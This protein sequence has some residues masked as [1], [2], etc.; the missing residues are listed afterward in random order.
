MFLESS[1]RSR[2]MFSYRRTFKQNFHFRR[3]NQP[4]LNKLCLTA[5]NLYCQTFPPLEKTKVVFWSYA[6]LK[7]PCGFNYL[8]SV[9]TAK[10][11]VLSSPY[12]KQDSCISLNW[13]KLIRK[14]SVTIGIHL[15]NGCKETHLE[16]YWC[17]NR[18]I[19]KYL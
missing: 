4:R 12:L 13:K 14:K 2:S 8:V 17:T 19:L 16:K 15:G 18:G 7:Q 1:C 5:A 6:R 3:A 10:V 9:W 11:A